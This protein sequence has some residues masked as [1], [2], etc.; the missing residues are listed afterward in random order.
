MSC[1]YSSVSAHLWFRKNGIVSAHGKLVSEL[2]VG[3]SYHLVKR[4]GC[5]FTLSLGASEQMFLI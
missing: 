2:E 4:S 3:R 5:Q 1:A